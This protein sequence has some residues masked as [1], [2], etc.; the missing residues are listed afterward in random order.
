MN[1]VEKD[2]ASQLH[3]FIPHTSGLYY[4]IIM[5]VNDTSRVVRMAIVR[6]APIRGIT[7]DCHSY[8]SRGVI[9]VSKVSK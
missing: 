2:I 8:N 6:D 5:I 1:D 9:I 3:L 7:Y 4:K